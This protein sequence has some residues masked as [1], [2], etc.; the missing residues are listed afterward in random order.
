[1]KIRF[2]LIVLLVLAALLCKAQ[3]QFG[4]AFV[5]GFDVEQV[6][7]TAKVIYKVKGNLNA[8][9]SVTFFIPEKSKF[10]FFGA[11]ATRTSNFG[12]ANLDF[13]YLIKLRRNPEFTPYLLFGGNAA[14]SRVKSDFNV[15]NVDTSIDDEFGI[16]LN[17]GF[18]S[19]LELSKHWILI[20][21]IKQIIGQLGQP[22]I[23]AG[24]LYRTR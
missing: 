16:G 18:G 24:I 17:L 6:G 1:M 12:A 2:P 19:K 11:D 23:S 8:S 3:I 7:L 14:Y 9:P 21:E 5:Y 15:S 22:V 10:D 4:P 13:H 20:G